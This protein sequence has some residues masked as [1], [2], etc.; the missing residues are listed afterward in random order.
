MP[1]WRSCA[2][3]PTRP[4]RIR[5][6]RASA[7]VFLCAGAGPGASQAGPAP[8]LENVKSVGPGNPVNAA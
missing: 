8:D 3:D 4:G 1:H 7:R 6:T 2:A 5:R